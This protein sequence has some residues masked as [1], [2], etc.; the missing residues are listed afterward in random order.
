MQTIDTGMKISNTTP[1]TAEQLRE[2]MNDAFSDY[3]VPMSL[4]RE[5]FDHMMRQRG[6]TPDVSR[7]AEIDGRIAALWLVSVRGDDAYLISS[8]TRPAFRSRGLA[9]ALGED[10]LQ[11]LKA[12]GVV[13][14]R[15]EVLEDNNAA[16]AL[17]RG[18]GMVTSRGLDCYRIPRTGITVAA[19]V[20]VQM[21]RWTEIADRTAR[22]CDWTPTWQN[23]VASLTAIEDQL[24]CVTACDGDDLLAYAVVAPASATLLQ[25][26]V[27]RDRRRR[28]LATSLLSHLMETAPETG[29]RVL[30]VQDDDRGFARFME[31]VGAERIVRQLELTRPL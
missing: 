5:Q 9:R 31:S 18:L 20:A 24:S 29:L 15:L 6:L 11:G 13:S 27:R 17:Y 12:G 28:K 26:A 8:G 1:F 7:V 16:I 19:G 25:I 2:A 3:A 14:F 23:S 4:S 10:C 21:R 22:L 30:N